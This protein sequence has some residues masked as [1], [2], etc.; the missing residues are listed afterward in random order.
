VK[1]PG[2]K[3]Q[4]SKPFEVKDSI[5]TNFVYDVTVIEAGKSGKYILKP[6]IAQS[7]ADQKFNEVKPKGKL[8]RHEEKQ[9]KKNQG[10]SEEKHGNS[11][12]DRLQLKLEGE[13][14]L[15]VEVTLVVTDNGTSVEGAT[16]SVNGTELEAKT[17]VDGRLTIMLPNTP[18]EIEIEATLGDKEGELELELEGPDEQY[19]EF[20]GT[21][22]AISEGNENASPWT[23][24]LEGVVG[25]VT[26][27]VTELEGTPSVDA[28]TEIEGVLKDNVIEDA[29]AE[30]ED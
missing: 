16:V 2:G 25:D 27:Y 17:D 26:V 1:L 28:R 7:G 5:V 10:K 19:E 8:E 29:K 12:E 4:I 20:K 15:G 18:G 22:T 24:T 11:E 21:I 14:G 30:I 13:I 6:Q 23:M 9:A 3:L